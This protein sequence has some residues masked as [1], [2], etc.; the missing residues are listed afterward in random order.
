MEDMKPLLSIFIGLLALVGIA[1]TFSSKCKSTIN[2]L[3]G[4][5]SSANSNVH[6][7]SRTAPKQPTTDDQRIL[8]IIVAITDIYKAVEKDN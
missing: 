6:K 3:L 5:L 4:A 1:Y 2:N 8:D 7:I